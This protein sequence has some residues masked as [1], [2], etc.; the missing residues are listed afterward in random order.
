MRDTIDLRARTV[1][2][3]MNHECW[4][5]ISNLIVLGEKKST[6]RVEQAILASFNNRAGVVDAD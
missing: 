1:N 3:M 2:S 4:K 5:D 6:S